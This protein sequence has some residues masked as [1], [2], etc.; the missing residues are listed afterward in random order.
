[1]ADR[2]LP[3]PLPEG[4][5]ILRKQR[6]EKLERIRQSGANPW[7][8]RFERSHTTAEARSA[9]TSNEEQLL[10]RLA[11][12]LI[13]LRDLGGM[14]FSHLKDGAGKLQLSFHREDLGERY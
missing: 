8:T 12:R 1:M 5:G 3:S 10:A 2:P 6:L 13:A 11:G 14:A 7:P 4:E 9:F